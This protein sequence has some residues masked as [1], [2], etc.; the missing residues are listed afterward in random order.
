MSKANCRECGRPFE[1]K[2]YWQKFCSPVC[3][4]KT[5]VRIRNE[6]VALGRKFKAQMSGAPPLDRD[7]FA[8]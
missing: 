4:T 6:E 2:R 5:F 8:A 7:L 3:R 1:R